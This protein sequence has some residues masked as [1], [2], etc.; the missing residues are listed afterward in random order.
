[1]SIQLLNDECFTEEEERASEQKPKP[2]P[3]EKEGEEVANKQA[4]SLPP[5]NEERPQQ[6]I[7][8]GTRNTEKKQL[9]PKSKKVQ[10]D[11]EIKSN[12]LRTKMS[13]LTEVGIKMAE[14]GAKQDAALSSSSS[15]V[16]SL[17][18]SSLDSS[19]ESLSDSSS[20]EDAE[21][22]K[23]RKKKKK[24]AK[25]RRRKREKLLLKLKKARKEL[26]KKSTEARTMVKPNP[27]PEVPEVHTEKESK[28]TIS[29]RDKEM[30]SAKTSRSDSHSS[31]DT[32]RRSWMKEREGSQDRYQDHEQGRPKYK[33]PKL[34]NEPTPST[35]RGKEGSPCPSVAIE[36]VVFKDHEQ[37][38]QEKREREERREEMIE[39]EKVRLRRRV[40]DIFPNSRTITSVLSDSRWCIPCRN[41]NIGQCEVP[42]KMHEMIQDRQVRHICSICHHAAGTCNSHTARNCKLDRF[43]NH[44]V[45]R[46]R[47]ENRRFLATRVDREQREDDRKHRGTGSPSYRGGRGR[48]HR[49]DYG[50]P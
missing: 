29:C 48:D 50:M 11:E 26:K 45:E 33:I 15:E 37:R 5:P 38:E 7:A 28:R 17:S 16:S 24:K 25:L 31:E 30:P 41:F 42:E 36:R 22:S 40:E 4:Q 9:V 43:L 20:N 35:S 34:S 32:G 19:E 18:A 39:Q 21:K 27:K 14:A 8:E 6:P 3:K 13:V 46:R 44:E 49:R 23:K 2:S 12:T 1:M 47:D 10:E